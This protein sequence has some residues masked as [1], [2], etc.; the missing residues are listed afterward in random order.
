MSDNADRLDALLRRFSVTA[1][2]FHAGALCGITEYPATPDVGQLHLIRRGPVQAQHGSR[3][4]E[5]IDVPSVVFYPRPLR[6][7]FVTDKRKGADLACAHVVFNS[8]AVNP[9]AQALPPVVVMPLAEIEGA[10]PLLETLFR[11]AFTQQCGRRHIVNRLFEVVLI[12]IVRTLMNRGD[13]EHGMLAGMSHPR[14]A[15]A[16]IAM[17][18]APGT[19][20]TLDELAK[21]AGM[22]RSHFAATFHEVVRTPPV[23]Y[24]T[25]YRISVAQDLLRR[26]ESLKNIV[27]VV[28]YGSSAAFSRAFSAVAGKSPREW[29]ASMEGV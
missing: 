11:E 10:D 20:W 28:G 2:M 27:G 25:H 24:L 5:E 13:M 4:R 29:R 15:K 22:S 9:I 19:A 3:R 16:L 18:E 1:R 26:G 23:D 14:L 8:A 6:H 7:R 21:R 12:L 17:H